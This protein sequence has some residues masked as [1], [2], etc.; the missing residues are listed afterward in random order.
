MLRAP[1]YLQK[2]RT[3]IFH[4]RMRIPKDLHQFFITPVLTK[5]LGTG[6]RQE[7]I[8]C[9]RMLSLKAYSQFEALRGDQVADRKYNR[10]D[11]HF[12][13][14]VRHPDGRVEIEGLDTDPTKPKEEAETF[15]RMLKALDPSQPTTQP[16]QQTRSTSS[17]SLKDVIK[18]YCDEKQVEKTWNKTTEAEVRAVFTLFIRIVGEVPL[19]DIGYETARHYKQTVQKLPPNLNK[20]SLYIGKTIEEIVAMDIDKTMAVKTI[21]KN[22]NRMSSLFDWAKKHGYVNDNYFSG[23]TLKDTRQADEKRSVFSKEDLKL[24][25]N[26]PIFTRKKYKHPYYFWLP[27]I[28]LHTGARINE[29]CQ[30]HL[31]DIRQEKNT[32]VFDIND[33]LE[34]KVKNHS[35]KRLLPIHSKLISVGLLKFVG[36]LRAKGETRLFPELVNRQDGYGA[37]ASR[38]FNGSFRKKV[39]V[40]EEGKVFH[41]FRHTVA[42]TLKQQG[43]TVDKTAAILGH[44][45]ESMSHGLY[46]K[47][48]G[49]DVLQP[50]IEELKFGDVLRGVGKF[51]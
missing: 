5:S 37:N 50:V 40:T 36:R 17:H 11:L 19:G 22:L 13:R 33:K 16:Q 1:S 42:N 27:L 28:A 24:I 30:L 18:A 39:G 14:I 12:D 20:N 44:K 2:T 38:W 51:R 47:A 31:D 32:W 41:S 7:A 21:N 6:N 29:L 45:D 43:T 8:R 4:F 3:G 9:A 48:F 15:E 25:F 10:L 46:G 34:K 23:L 49:V 35:S 26:D